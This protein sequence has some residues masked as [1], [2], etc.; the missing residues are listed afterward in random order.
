MSQHSYDIAQTEPRPR[1]F[2]IAAWL[3]AGGT[4]APLLLASSPVRAL[5]AFARQTGLA[6]TSCHTAYPQLNAF[7]REFKLSGYTESLANVPWYDKFAFMIQPS[8]THTSS[9]LS[10]P[11]EDFG[12]NNNFAFTQTSLFFGGKLGGF[13]QAT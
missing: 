2:T 13:V 5:P 8:F 10:D 12:D 9:D 11:P 1:R 6:C 4:L 7:G 3:I